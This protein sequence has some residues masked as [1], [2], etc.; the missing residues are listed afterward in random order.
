MKL[1]WRKTQ[2]D[3]LRLV[4]LSNLERLQRL[5]HARGKR[6]AYAADMPTAKLEDA[7]WRVLD[8]TALDMG[9]DFPPGMPAEHR[10]SEIQKHLAPM[11]HP[12]AV[13]GSRWPSFLQTAR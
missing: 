13:Q 2:P 10:V 8:Q 9:L 5:F 6:F 11:P 1:P 7:L 4:V 3:R 12:G